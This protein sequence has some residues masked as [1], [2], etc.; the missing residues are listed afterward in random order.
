MADENAAQLGMRLQPRCQVYFIADNRVVHAILAAE[1]ADGAI[2]GGDADT[3]LEWFLQ[4]G[5]APLELK[6]PYPPL[7][8]DG[9]VDARESVLFDAFRLGVA[10]ER[11]DR[12]AHVLVNSCAVLESNLRH[13]RQVV[14][15]KTGQLLGLQIV[16]GC[17]EICDVGEEYGQFFAVRRDLDAAQRLDRLM[18][19]PFFESIRPWIVSTSPRKLSSFTSHR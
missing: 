7:H 16:G 10:E 5:I 12:V 4:P 11:Q 6:L 1:V 2:A 19:L 13:L 15:K 17:G 14:I 3:Q 8:C 9:H 18:R